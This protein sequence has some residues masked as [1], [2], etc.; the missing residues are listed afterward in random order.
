MVSGLT[1][2]S[3]IHFKLIFVSGIRCGYNFILWHVN[4]QS[5]QHHLLKKLLR[6]FLVIKVTCA[7]C[8]K[9]RKYR[10]VF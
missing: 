10:K 2:K 7:Q 5:S 6:S 1:F 3:L 8:R 4:V 9:L